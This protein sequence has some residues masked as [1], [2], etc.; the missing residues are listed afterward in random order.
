RDAG[1]GAGPPRRRAS[2][3]GGASSGRRNV[4]SVVPLRHLRVR[5]DVRDRRRVREEGLVDPRGGRVDRD[6]TT[7]GRRR[8]RRDRRARSVAGAVVSPTA[9]P[10]GS[11]V[12]R[13]ESASSGASSPTEGASGEG[14][15]EKSAG[16][17]G[18]SAGSDG[19]ALVVPVGGGAAADSPGSD[20]V[21]AEVRGEASAAAV[22]LGEVSSGD[23]IQLSAPRY[24]ALSRLGFPFLQH[25]I[26]CQPWSATTSSPESDGAESFKD[27][28]LRWPEHT[29][30][31]TMAMISSWDMRDVAGEEE[32][33]PT[34]PTSACS[35][36]Q[37]RI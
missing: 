12:T 3:T 13:T 21:A 15:S 35:R 9:P 6:D 18:G 37:I 29:V 32:D 5:G 17:E 27:D 23:A 2:R 33:G 7:G 30:L 22:R 20:Q 1:R 31:R 19:E 10:E 28:A 34:E 24:G 16:E 14:R 36:A 26:E 25:A 8:D 4:A 11:S